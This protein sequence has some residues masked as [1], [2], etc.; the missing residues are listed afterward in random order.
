MTPI[1]LLIAVISLVLFFAAYYRVATRIAS[2]QRSLLYMA[3]E[4]ALEMRTKMLSKATIL[5]QMKRVGIPLLIAVAVCTA[6]SLLIPLFD[7]AAIA[8]SIA[9]IAYSAVALAKA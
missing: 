6:L 3:T 5:L 9:L 4:K 8:V 1:T 2:L 7:L